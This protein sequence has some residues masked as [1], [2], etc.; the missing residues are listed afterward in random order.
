VDYIV[1][2]CDVIPNYIMLPSELK[3]ANRSK[4]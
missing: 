4:A 1:N 3:Y 2:H